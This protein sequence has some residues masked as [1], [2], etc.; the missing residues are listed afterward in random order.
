MTPRINGSDSDNG[1][2]NN[3]INNSDSD[4][5]SDSDSSSDDMDDSVDEI[6]EN[7][8]EFDKIHS[9]YY[10]G[11]CKLIRTPTNVDNH[12]L[13]LNAI[14]AKMFAKYSYSTILQYL[15][16]Y[17]I[18]RTYQPTI[19]IMQLLIGDFGARRRIAPQSEGERLNS[20]GLH[21]NPNE[22]ERTYTIVKKTHWLRLVQRHWKKTMR[23]RAYII[24]KRCSLSSILN[25][26]VK[27]RYP[28]GLNVLPGLCG[29][30]SAYSR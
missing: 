29:M 14:S 30:M 17:S 11:I 25:F 18:I 24:N 4:S 22:F 23:Q 12:F 7:D 6:Y 26:E 21:S 2:Y 19:E 15:T 20:V 5:D 9:H 10:I 28:Y 27:G 8:D 13:L 16:E 1:H 3:I